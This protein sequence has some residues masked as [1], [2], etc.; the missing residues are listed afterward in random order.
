MGV[1]SPLLQDLKHFTLGEGRIA[2]LPLVIRVN[3][4]FII[5]IHNKSDFSQLICLAYPTLCK[6]YVPRVHI[7]LYV[8]IIQKAMQYLQNSV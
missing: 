8:S 3:T 1:I 4:K 7:I 2:S 5:N 6:Y